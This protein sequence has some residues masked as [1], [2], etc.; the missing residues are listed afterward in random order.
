MKVNSTDREKWKGVH[1][2]KRQF[3]L[4]QK[5]TVMHPNL[6]RSLTAIR[7]ERIHCLN[8]QKGSAILVLA[9]SGSGKTHLRNFLK[10]RSPDRITDVLTEIPVI[11]FDVPTSATARSMCEAL[12]SAMGEPVIG[13]G[14]STLLLDRILTL[15]PRIGTEL[16]I[17]DNVQDIP[18]KR[19]EKGILEIGGFIRRLIDE[20]SCLVLLLGTPAAREIITA[21]SQLRRRTSRLLEIDYFYFGTESEKSAFARFLYEV[22]NL[23][24]L[25][26]TSFL[27]KSETAQ[28]LHHATFGIP[29]YLFQLLSEAIEESVSEDR[30]A[31]TNE[32]LAKA[33]MKVFADSSKLRNPFTDGINRPLTGEGEPFY[34]WFDESNPSLRAPS[35]TEGL[36]EGK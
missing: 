33:Y 29:S 25:G 30:E 22:D 7:R 32:D 2:T 17:I 13:R 9:P 24:P 18:E 28:R 4:Q 6:F 26:E 20:T 34:R 23:L 3:Y 10:R 21:N 36:I 27:H 35:K 31:L 14:Q 1:I 5:L 15:L 8:E 11:A 16:I 19:R 12:L